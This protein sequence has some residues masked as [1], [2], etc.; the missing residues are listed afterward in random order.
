MLPLQKMSEDIVVIRIVLRYL[1]FFCD[2][3][4][5][6]DEF[7]GK[8]YAI[9][10]RL[11]GTRANSRSHIIQTEW[12]KWINIDRR[13]L[14]LFSEHFQ[15]LAP[16]QQVLRTKRSFKKWRYDLTSMSM[17]SIGWWRLNDVDIRQIALRCL[18]LLPNF[19]LED[20]MRLTLTAWLTWVFLLQ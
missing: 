1:V 18:L 3:N 11:A 20:C 15:A 14:D 8:K 2:T 4:W 9:W 13:C 16:V 6:S 12:E 5:I 7:R 10:N 17:Q 19:R